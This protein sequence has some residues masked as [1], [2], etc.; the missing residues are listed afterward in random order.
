M[1]SYGIEIFNS[2]GELV[3]ASDKR[4]CQVLQ[5]GHVSLGRAKEKEVCINFPA[6]ARRPQVYAQTSGLY[7]VVAENDGP[8]YN[9]QE[10]R[11]YWHVIW[12]VMCPT[13]CEFKVDGNGKYCGIWFRTSIAYLGKENWDAPGPGADS[14]LPF[15]NIPYVIFF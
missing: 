9:L 6:T 15:D 3:F 7:N 1:S 4:T 2:S 5:A 13:V 8:L 14:G 10:E 11:W 12:W